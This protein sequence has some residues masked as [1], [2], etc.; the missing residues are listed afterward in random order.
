MKI[1]VFVLAVIAGMPVARAADTAAGK[2]LAEQVCAACH[3]ANGV[4]VS[5]LIP[6][7][8][9]QKEKYISAQ[10]ATFKAG[11]RTNDMMNAIAGQLNSSEIES[12]AAYF[13]SLP[14]APAGTATSQQLPNVAKTHVAFPGDYKGTYT[15]YMTIDFPDRKQVRYYFAS[16]DAMA[17]AKD[18]KPMPNGATFFVEVHSTKLGA[19]KKPI[20][21]ADGFLAPEKLLFFTA[22]AKGEG[23]GKDIPDML[24]NGD[25]NYA[26]FNTD[27]SHRKGPNQAE[28][29][30]CHKPLDK[31]DYLFTLKALRD[32]AMKK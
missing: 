16:P 14:G 26:V 2:A 12:L 8:A 22:M 3:G 32:A 18:G 27:K 4:S 1:L 20:K 25:W 24:K 23:W 15:K 13:A 10:L 11:K 29:F 28:C 21:G 9:G 6:N 31:D 17:A 19:D 5:A 7:L 30:A